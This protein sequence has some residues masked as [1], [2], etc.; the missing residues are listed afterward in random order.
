MT[1]LQSMAVQHKQYSLNIM[2][3][4]IKAAKQRLRNRFDRNLYF[5]DLE[6]LKDKA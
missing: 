2:L 6:G 3:P 4:W 5:F 1:G